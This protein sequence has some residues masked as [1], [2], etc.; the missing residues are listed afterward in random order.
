[1]F[2]QTFATADLLSIGTLVVL[3]ALLSADNAI[4]LAIMVRHL[5]EKERQKALLYG[6]GGAFVF[7]LVAIVFAAVVLEQWWLQAIG[8]GYLIFL[9]LKHF[10]VS[11]GESETKVKKPKGGFWPTV[12]A[13]ELTDIAFALDSVL[14][15]IAVISTP[16]EGVQN[17]K[18]WVV[19]TGAMIGIVLLRFAA[20]AFAKILDRYPGLDH[21]AYT[22]VGWVGI[23]LLSHALESGHRL[24]AV[25]VA[26][27]GM[28]EPVFWGGMA[29]ILLLGIGMAVAKRKSAPVDGH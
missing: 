11:H 13:V 9:A 23:K 27:P 18:V 29:A 6:L 25:P 26:V 21:V 7:R 15:G 1:M 12:I 20:G 14:A 10:V 2:G 3:E 24:H 28:T 16:R 4:V 17:D 5:E 8:G 22:L 19:V